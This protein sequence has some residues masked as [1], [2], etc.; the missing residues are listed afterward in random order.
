MVIRIQPE[1]RLHRSP[2]GGTGSVGHAT[3]GAGRDFNLTRTESTSLQRRR[4][5]LLA[6]VALCVQTARAWP[7]LAGERPLIDH[8]ALGSRFTCRGVAVWPRLDE[9]RGEPMTDHAG[10]ALRFGLS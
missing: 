8:I 5:T 2:P 3:D 1:A 9:R 7:E 6:D 10:M 4:A